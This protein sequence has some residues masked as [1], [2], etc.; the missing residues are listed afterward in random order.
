MDKPERKGGAQNDKD[1]FKKDPSK[2]E[3]TQAIPGVDDD[4]KKNSA[5]PDRDRV[6]PDV[7]D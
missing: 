6:E 4:C 2:R 5:T 3:R 1:P 7:V